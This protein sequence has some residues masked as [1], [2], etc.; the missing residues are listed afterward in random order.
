MMEVEARRIRRFRNQRHTNTLLPLHLSS[1]SHHNTI[2]CWYCDYKIFSFNKPLFDFGQR[3]AKFLKVWFSIGVGFAVSVLL[4]VTLFLLWELARAL[5]LCGGSN[6]LGNLTSAFLFRFSPLLPGLSLSLSDAG[7]I[8][9]STVISVFVHEVGHAVA[10]T[11]EG[12]Q[13][14]YIAI[15]MA[16]LF[17]GA[18]VAFNYELLQ[19]LPHFTALRMYSAGIWHNAVCCA[20]CGLALFLLPLLLFP[21][22]SSS[23]GPMVLN[24]PRTSPLSGFLVP[25]DVIL[26]VDN[27]P[28][29][30]AQEWLEINTLTYD[31]KLNNVNNSQHTGDLW[32]AN[33]GYCVPS[34]MMEESKITESLENQD[35]CPS[36][37]AAFVKVSC[38]VNI[39][40][41]DGQ[42]QTDNL[43]RKRNMYCLNAKDVVKLNKCGDHWGPVATNGSG[44]TCSQDEFCL[45]PVQEPG[46]VW[47][48][49]TYSS[50]SPECSLQERI[51]SSVSE[52][53]GIK[54]TNCGGTFIFVGDVI[55]MAHSIQLTSYRPRLGLKF[56]AYLPNLLERILMWTFHVSLA[57]AV[58]NGLPV[59]F[60]DG[61]YILEASLSH[62]TWL[63][64]RKRKKV[65]KLC[66]LGGSLIS[67]I[68]FFQEL[69]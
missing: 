29:R 27:V 23:H 9:I 22:Y 46:L 54:E 2:S 33:K 52:T 48:E 7:Y 1:F 56:V 3:H 14:E 30:N 59:Y 66:L 53:S 62:F 51:R 5:H 8:C 25:G 26:S 18:L 6:K 63:S 44:C 43:N 31:I 42:S 24:V 28:I 35:A 45:A 55:S 57:L 15:F 40:L 60:L 34:V 21:F 47:V 68:G 64:P 13:I 49:I 17:P 67:V 10:A 19:S 37:L 16:V 36:G 32:L 4:G 58:L 69:L 65:L 61:E 50:P 12:I 20:A 11:S 39:T 38:S 41:D